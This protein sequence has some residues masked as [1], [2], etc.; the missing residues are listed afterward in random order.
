MPAIA[1]KL[2][3]NSI[4]KLSCALCLVSVASLFEQSTPVT[5]QEERHLELELYIEKYPRFC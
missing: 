4:Y 3:I 5:L 1:V 2:I